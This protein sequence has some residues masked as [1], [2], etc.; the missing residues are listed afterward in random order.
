LPIGDE[1]KKE[2][3][4]VREE[5]YR[6]AKQ[7]DIVIGYIRDRIAQ[8]YNPTEAWALCANMLRGFLGAPEE[9]TTKNLAEI[10][11][12]LAVRIVTDQP[13]RKPEGD[14]PTGPQ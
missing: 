10:C 1:R 12:T 3:D 11:A 5:G 7:A 4:K 9:F 2:F 8:G 14:A 13:P 6:T